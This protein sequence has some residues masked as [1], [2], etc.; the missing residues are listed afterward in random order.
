MTVRVTVVIPTYRRPVA[1]V[2]CLRALRAQDWPLDRFEVVIVEDGEPSPVLAD[3]RAATFD[4]LA[5]SWESQPHAGP[6]Q[7]RNLGAS[8]AARDFL[9]FTDDDCRPRPGWLRSLAG[10][11]ERRPDAIVG[12]H[13]VNALSDNACSTASQGLVTYIVDYFRRQG[14]PFF[15]SNNFAL[16]KAAFDRL[17][18]FD[19]SFPLAGGE[20]RD[21]C[22]RGVELG[23]E[24]RHVP[25][26]IIDHYHALDLR[27]FWRQHFRYGRGAWQYQAKAPLAP[28]ARRFEP[29]RFYADLVLFPFHQAEVEKKLRVCMCLCL[30]QVA[31]AAGYFAER[32]GARSRARDPGRSKVP[33]E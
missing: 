24:L 8:R 17:G 31:N 13:T 14:T 9:V 3:V 30:S 21:F 12:G 27:S 32:F 33:R 28:G 4:G 5:V 2:E 23:I 15:A 11:L 19:V 20:D 26:A 1:V 25:D 16:S 29:L 6:A 10:E 7:A 22:R 18:G